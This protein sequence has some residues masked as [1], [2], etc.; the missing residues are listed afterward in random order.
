MCVVERGSG[1]FEVVETEWLESAVPL[2]L[3]RH[4]GPT[5]HHQGDVPDNYLLI[6]GRELPHMTLRVLRVELGG[7]EG[8]GGREGNVIKEVSSSAVERFNFC[9]LTITN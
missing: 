6:A 5:P 8:E 2:C 3:L 1:A 4:A 9:C 7:R